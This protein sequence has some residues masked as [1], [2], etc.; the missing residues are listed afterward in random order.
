VRDLVREHFRD[1]LAHR[2]RG[3]RVGQEQHLPVEDRAGVLQFRD[4]G[5]VR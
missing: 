4:S 2:Y 3:V 5:T 1:A